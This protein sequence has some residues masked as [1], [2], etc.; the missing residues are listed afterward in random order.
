VPPIR[1]QTLSAPTLRALPGL[2]QVTP[3]LPVTT[4]EVDVSYHAVEDRISLTCR[5]TT[6]AELRLYMTRRLVE[7]LINSLGGILANSSALAQRASPVV[8]SDVIM[9]EHHGAV[10]AAPVAARLSVR[11]QAPPEARYRY[12][13]TDIDLTVRPSA[14]GV[15][16]RERH[17]ELLRFEASRD[18]V[19]RLVDL[20]HRT[21]THAGWKPQIDINWLA[22]GAND[23]V[24]N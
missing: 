16:F 22:T 2:L 17:Q 4:R 7:R 21:A 11:Q 24:V 14:F 3:S 13:V 10:A 18:D 5:I 8:R 9:M 1:P 19:H 23:A 15:T 20:L 12:L 6:S